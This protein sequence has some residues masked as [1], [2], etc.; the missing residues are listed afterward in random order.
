MPALSALVLDKEICFGLSTL[1][2]GLKKHVAA[3]PCKRPW[4]RLEHLT[5]TA[6]M[7]LSASMEYA[8]SKGSQKAMPACIYTTQV[9]LQ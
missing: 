6:D 1:M 5:A 3:T 7:W 2:A 4:C 8:R 9:C